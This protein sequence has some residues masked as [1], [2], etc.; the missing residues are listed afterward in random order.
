MAKNSRD[1]YGL[2][3]SGP[4]PALAPTPIIALRSPQTSDI[5]FE[6][7]SIWIS[8]TTAQAW[9]LTRV[10]A[11]SATWAI[12][13]PGSSDVDTL[14]GDGGGAISPT[15]GTVILA[16]GT[17]ITTVGTAT[18]GRITFNMDAA[19]TLATSVTAPLYTAGAGVDTV[20]EAVAGQDIVF[21]MSTNDGS[22]DVLFTDSDDATVFSIDSNGTLG[23][24]AGLTVTGAFTQTAGIVSISEDNSANAVGIA[25]GNTARAVD[26]ASSA[27]AH[28]VTIGSATGAASLDLLAGTA[29]FTL[30]GGTATTYT[31]SG[32]GANTGLITIGGGTGAQTLSLMNDDAGAK[33][34]NIANGLAGNTLN[35]ATGI[36][37]GVQ[38]VNISTGAAA[39]NSTVNIL[40]GTATAGTQTMNLGTGPSSKNISIGNQTGNSFLVLDAAAGEWV[41]TTGNG[42]AMTLD[43]AGAFVIDATTT[44]EL[45]STGGVISI[46]NDAVNQ[47]INIGTAGTRDIFVG[48][49]TADGGVFLSCGTGGATFATNATVHTTTLGSTT[50]A[51]DTVVQSG[52]AGLVINAVGAAATLDIDAVGI[53]SIN[54]S[55]AAINIGDDANAFDMNFGTGA[56]QRDIIIGNNTGTT[57]VVI[58]VGT[59]AA[60]FGANATDHT[61]T[62]GST[63]GGSPLILQGGTTDITVR[64]TVTELTSEFTTRS[65]D[66]I[67]FTQSPILQSVLTTGVAPTGGN[68]DVNI[69][70]LQDGVFMEQFIIGTQTIIT[71]R[72]D[73][74]GLSVALDQL[75]TEGVEYNF[76]AARD[77]NRHAFTIGTS[78]PF[79]FEVS[80]N[81]TD[82]SA[83]NPFMIGFRKTEANNAVLADYT[84][85]AVLGIN[86]TTSIANVTIL[87][88]L[89]G[90]GQNATNTTD[91]WIGGDGGTTVIRVNVQTDGTTTFRIDDQDPSVTSAYQFDNGDVVTPF[92]YLIQGGDLSPVHLISMK[93]GF[94]A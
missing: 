93:A 67:T 12:S 13:S 35:I 18:P 82:V 44:L 16:G 52:T 68:G 55:A 38:A 9:H 48:N 30:E 32:T 72:M 85:Y 63:G 71:P 73:A 17:N 79:F 83:G 19:I 64:G 51:S 31:I 1:G 66:S 5:G 39:A 24:F 92:I 88:E 45:N 75:V 43:C 78:D 4:I 11:G 41:A 86:T 59:G 69:M 58:N 84:D 87:H 33:I 23:A 36:N 20:V 74:I 89:N 29:N 81:L 6:I 28:T 62:I 25:N 22:T 65:G 60:S 54:S 46:G 7:G 80:M 91:G 76:G 49:G 90:T 47:S 14:T 61:T 15:V 42:G 70:S 94:I 77:N 10:L 2:G 34:V 50:G 53:L 8:T 3:T 57:S 37:A 56:A 21:N 40:T 27:A 26:I